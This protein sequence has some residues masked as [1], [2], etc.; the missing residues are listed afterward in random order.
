MPTSSS[1]G[2]IESRI[3]WFEAMTL[4]LINARCMLLIIRFL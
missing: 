3:L 1:A 4:I 2:E